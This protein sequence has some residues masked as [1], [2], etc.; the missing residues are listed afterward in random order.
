MP[1]VFLSED[2][3]VRLISQAVAALLIIARLKAEKQYKAAEQQVDEALEGQLG[4]RASLLKELDDERLKEMLTTNGMLE[5]ERFL[6]VADLFR[7]SAELA[8]VRGDQVAFKRDG[9]RALGFYQE[10]MHNGGVEVDEA[11]PVKIEA[12]KAMLAGSEKAGNTPATNPGKSSG[13][14][15]RGIKRRAADQ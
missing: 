1:N 10:A 5:M 7:E 9:Q 2:Y 12:L 4:L 11:L 3:L 14:G 15:K 13:D 8:Q 6:L